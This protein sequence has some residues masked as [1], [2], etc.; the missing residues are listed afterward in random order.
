MVH[1]QI[2]RDE[3]GIEGVA[4]GIN[5]HIDDHVFGTGNARIVDQIVDAAK[6]F[7]GLINGAL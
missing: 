2:V 3:I 7:D 5:V 1:Q 4:P 6:C